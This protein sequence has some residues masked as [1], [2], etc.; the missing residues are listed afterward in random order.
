VEL[1]AALATA[2]R[3]FGALSCGEVTPAAKRA[4]GLA[5]ARQAA[6]RPVPE[7]PRAWT[8]LLLCADRE[9]QLDAA[10]AAASQ[11]RALGET[12]SSLVPAALWAKY[13]EI[14]AVVDRE[15]VGLDIDADVA[16]AVIWVDFRKV[17]VAPVHVVL[18]AGEHVIAAAAGSKRGW[19]AGTAIAK[20]KSLRV[21]LEDAAGP[22]AEVAQ[23]VAGWH[24]Q[25]PAASELAW[26]LGRVHA[27][28]ALVRSGDTIEAWAQAGRSEVPRL[29]SGDKAAPI[30][31]A[32]RVLGQ[33]VAQVRSW[34]ERAPDPDRPLLVESTEDRRARGDR[35]ARPT[36]WWVYAAIAGA[37]ALGAG[38]IYLNDSASDRQ[39]VELHYP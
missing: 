18:A 21:P 35:T 23:R 4:I 34:N 8:Y 11:L 32:S 37:A 22:W 36:R 14:D 24:G 5:A 38:A 16:G 15:L 25:R 13:P 33:V 31:E 9:G 20:Q 39:R 30:G 28:I 2:Q 10:H 17:G 29:I 27:R 26:V 1:A 3:A 7:L 6:G 19:A 12:G